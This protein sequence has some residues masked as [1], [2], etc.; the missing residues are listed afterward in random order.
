MKGTRGG[1]GILGGGGRGG[2]GG[3]MGGEG[4]P[5][6]GGRDTREA[7]A[8]VMPYEEVKATPS[9]AIGLAR[10]REMGPA[11]ST[12]TSS[13]RVAWRITLRVTPVTPGRVSR[14]KQDTSMYAA[15]DA[16]SP[17]HA[18]SPKAASPPSS[19]FSPS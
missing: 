18:L 12:P 19:F 9:A 13:A 16:T 6:G 3:K 2:G 10:S 1:T 11:C 15:E 8:E 14:T 7:D 17:K 4:S 5:G